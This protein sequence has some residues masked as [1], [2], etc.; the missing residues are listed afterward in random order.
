MILILVGCPAGDD[1]AGDEAGMGDESTGV[2]D[3]SGGSSS[4]A[5][6]A[7]VTGHV[8]RADA[9]A[10]AEDNDGIGTIYVGVFDSCEETATLVDFAVV[11]G[12]DVSATDSVV[13]FT[14]DDLDPG[15][16]DLRVFLDDNED[17]DPLMPAPGPG[18]IA[19]PM[20]S[21]V[22]VDG[23]DVEVDIGLTFT[24]PAE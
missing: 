7:S 12:A 9:A 10:V 23:A 22:T 17:A 6:S 21:T 4:G 16:Y 24:F 20:C 11:T 13:D 2:V 3:P 8:S 1:E 18:D 5:A 19:G 15:E 14:V